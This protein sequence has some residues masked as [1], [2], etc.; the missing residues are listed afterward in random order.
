MR[1]G[2][3]LV[4]AAVSLVGATVLSGA[5]GVASAAPHS[6]PTPATGYVAQAVPTETASLIGTTHLDFGGV[7]NGGQPS[8]GGSTALPT[9]L[10]PGQQPRTP[11]VG[12]QASATTTKH[13]SLSRTSLKANPIDPTVAGQSVAGPT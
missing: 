11:D 3:S 13:S 6:N 1:F 9:T 10:T 7:A 2:R 5:G 4:G 12:D 8:S